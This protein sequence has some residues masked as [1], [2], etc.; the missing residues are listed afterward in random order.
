M[1]EQITDKLISWATDLED[2]ALQ[3]ALRTSRLPWIA[4]HVALMPDAHWGMGSTVGSVIPTKGA[5]LPAAVGV[6]IGC[7]MIAARVGLHADQLPDTIS[8][9]M[10]LLRDRIPAGVGRGRGRSGKVD[11]L[12]GGGPLHKF[13]KRLEEATPFKYMNEQL[14][15]TARNQLGSLGAGNHFVEVS[16]D[17]N[18]NVWLVLHSGSRGVGN[19][20]A[21]YHIQV[22]RG[23]M[24]DYLKEGGTPLED[25]DLAHLVEGTPEFESYIADMLWS[26]DFAATNREVMMTEALRSFWEVVGYETGRYDITDGYPVPEQVVNCHHNFTLKE[27][28]NGEKIWLTR[29]GAISARGGQWGIIPGSMGTKSYITVGLD[30]DASYK[31]SAHGAGRRMSRG[32]ARRELTIES[33]N[34]AMAGKV[35]NS[36]DAKALIDE[37]PASYKDIDVVMENQKDLVEV[38]YTLRQILNFKGVS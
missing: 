26:Q 14:K 37:A 15:A 38:Q 35:W 7:G 12:G 3:Q 4:G 18:D 25:P 11:G 16:L 34:E 22:A 31:S 2:E 24:E 29:K 8:P 21:Q 19:K 28:H 23:L 9:I 36:N 13:P 5:I 30:N 20:L 17:Q 32:R 33:F 10:P 6:D 1:P 27:E